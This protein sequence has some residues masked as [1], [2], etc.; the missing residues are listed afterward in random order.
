MFFILLGLFFLVSAVFRWLCSIFFCYWCRFCFV[1][2]IIF[3]CV[4]FLVLLL[5]VFVLF[6]WLYG[7]DFYVFVFYV[8]YY[9][10]VFVGDGTNLYIYYL[11]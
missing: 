2:Y 9:W 8:C 4:C 7:W 11:N 5:L 6:R 3:L 1:G 10:C